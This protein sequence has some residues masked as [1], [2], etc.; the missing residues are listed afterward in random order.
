MLTSSRSSLA[1]LYAV[2][3]LGSLLAFRA[4]PRKEGGRRD[5]ASLLI[6]ARGDVASID[7]RLEAALAGERVELG[8]RRARPRLDGRHGRK[9]ATWAARDERVHLIRG[10]TLPPGWNGKQ[11]A[12]WNL[13]RTASHDMMAFVDADVRLRPDAL[14]RHCVGIDQRRLDLVGGFPHERTETIAEALE[15]PQSHVL[16]LGRLPLPSRGLS[17]APISEPETG[18][19]WWRGDGPTGRP[20]PFRHPRNAA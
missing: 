3:T 7:A 2:M 15:I 11:H 13:S 20:G 18:S 9:G 19:S 12:C 8:G 17:A 4:P 6:P 5:A 1:A 10:P 14:A 16:F